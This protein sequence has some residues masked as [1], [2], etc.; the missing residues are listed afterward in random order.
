MDKTIVSSKKKIAVIGGGCAGLAAAL[1]MIEKGYDVSIFEKE[2]DAGGICGGAKLNGNI[3][4]Y[5]PH[6]F[7]TIDKDI[8]SDIKSIAGDDMFCIERTILIK[9]LGRYFNFPLSTTD[10]I[11]K[12]PPLTILRAF[13]SFIFYFIKGS[14]IRH[15]P[16]T[17]ETVLLRSYGKTLYELFFKSYITHVWGIPPSKFSPKFAKQR[18]P[19]LAVLSWL[20]KLI[21]KLDILLKRRV[22]TSNYVE[23]VEGNLYTTRKGF[24]GIIE[25]IKEEIERKRGHIFL[26]K[27]VLGVNRQN[28]LITHIVS[29]QDL[30]RFDCDGVISTA[31]INELVRMINP[32]FSADIIQ[33]AERLRFRA[34][35]FVGFLIKKEKVLPASFL[36]FREHSF[37]RITDSSYF[38]FDVE[39]KGHTLLVAEISCGTDDRFWKDDEFSKRSVLDD[40]VREGFISME[41]VKE[42]HVFK[43][44]HAYPIYEL[45]FENIL[46]KLFNAVDSIE[47]LTVAGRQGKFQYV[48]SHIAIKMGYEAADKLDLKLKK[49]AFDIL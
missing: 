48:N 18:I 12:L 8:L 15:N 27:K 44:E 31:P 34:L 47:N 7:H 41:I 3:Y 24:F 20:F 11:K 2:P 10:V 35:V 33:N 36:Y 23:K 1:H 37:N 28:N 38:G 6:I 17:S 25:K 5:G 49:L 22:N 30:E 13:F 9:F 43:T 14:I 39:P 26:N 29:G 16:E 46:E 42:A 19:Q 40:L 4:E 45:G 32:Y 21:E